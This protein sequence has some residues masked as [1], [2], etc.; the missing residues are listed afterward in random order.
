MLRT[1]GFSTIFLQGVISL[2]LFRFSYIRLEIHELWRDY[3]QYFFGFFHAI[4]I[5]CIFVFL[6]LSMIFRYFKYY[7]QYPLVLLAMLLILIIP[8]LDS[9]FVLIFT[10]Y[11]LI[12]FDFESHLNVYH[13]RSVADKFYLVFNAVSYIL[14]YAD[15]EMKK[16][17]Q[18]LKLPCEKKHIFTNSIYNL[19]GQFFSM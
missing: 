18:S 3:Q 8:L 13:S 10:I 16:L 7:F 2:H 14:L 12:F 11:L 6:Y 19:S 1:S 4:Q 9:T 5:C 15:A 17:Q